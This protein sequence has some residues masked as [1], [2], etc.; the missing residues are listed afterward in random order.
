MYLS[1]MKNYC[2]SGTFGPMFLGSAVNF[3]SSGS[4]FNYDYPA[5]QSFSQLPILGVINQYHEGII[6][7]DSP[8]TV[9]D[10]R[11]F[12]INVFL[13]YLPLAISAIWNG[14]R[15]DRSPA[16]FS[17]QRQQALKAV[18][19]PVAQYSTLYHLSMF[20]RKYLELHELSGHAIVQSV[21]ALTVWNITKEMMKIGTPSQKKCFSAIALGLTVTNAIWTYNTAANCHTVMDIAGAALL[22]GSINFGLETGKVVLSQLTAKFC[23]RSKNDVRW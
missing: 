2:L 8:A 13:C 12:N 3:L 19:L 17:P 1:Q 4:L 15:S 22:V 6:H 9:H 10:I 23:S 16:I 7:R 14:V 20:V 18:I 11:L 21:F 5:C